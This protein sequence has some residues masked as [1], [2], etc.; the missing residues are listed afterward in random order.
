[1][2]EGHERLKLRVSKTSSL[3]ARKPTSRRHSGR[4]QTGHVWTA[5]AMQGQ[6]LT[7]CEAFGC[8]HVYG[9]FSLRGLPPC[10]AAAVAAGPDVIR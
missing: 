7:F 8:S 1:M 6:N 10:D 3:R 5:P 9:L 4:S 2:S